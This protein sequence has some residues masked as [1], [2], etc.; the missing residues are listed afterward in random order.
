MSK[1]AATEVFVRPATEKKGKRFW[2]PQKIL[3]TEIGFDAETE[4]C[5][6]RYRFPCRGRE[7]SGGRAGSAFGGAPRAAAALWAM[8]VIEPVPRTTEK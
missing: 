4:P 2:L 7:P 3:P 6:V 8:S 5:E 1:N